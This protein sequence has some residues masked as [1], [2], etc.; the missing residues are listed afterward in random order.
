MGKDSLV[1]LF[2][3]RALQPARHGATQC[4][5]DKLTVSD[6]PCARS[7][8]A[9]SCHRH[10]CIDAAS[11][12]RSVLYVHW[13]SAGR[14]KPELRSCLLLRRADEQRP[15][16]TTNRGGPGDGLA[17]YSPLQ[18][19]LHEEHGL[20]CGFCTPGI[21][22]TFEAYLCENPEP[23]EAEVREVMSGNLCRCT[24][25]QNIVKAVLKAAA[26]LREAA[27]GQETTA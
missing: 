22:L 23:T 1:E 12:S 9:C 15:E 14:P 5:Q 4:R 24:G 7:N 3:Q 11:T 18:R 27:Q 25:Y 20:Q 10:P 19:A 6:V 16:I 8:S 26:A 2:S 17:K 13:F 21:V